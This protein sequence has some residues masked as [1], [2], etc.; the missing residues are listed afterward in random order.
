MLKNVTADLPNVK[1]MTFK[2]LTVDFAEKMDARFIVRGLRAISD[3]DN[4]L[5]MAQT[6]SKLHKG[7]DTVF[8]PTSLNYAFLSSTTVK[9]VAA[10]GGDLSQFVPD[11]VGERLHEKFNVKKGE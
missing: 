9:E 10:F 7:V 3:F 4:E 8:L 1:I 6:N 5:Q 11:Y 2:G